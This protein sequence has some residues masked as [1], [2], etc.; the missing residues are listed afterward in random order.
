LWL[1]SRVLEMVMGE[2]PY[3]GVG[4]LATSFI[5]RVNWSTST[6]CACR[7]D[8]RRLASYCKILCT[9]ISPW[10]ITIQK[11]HIQTI[12]IHAHPPSPLNPQAFHDSP[13]HEIN[14]RRA[15]QVSFFTLPKQTVVHAG[16][17]DDPAALEVQDR[18]CSERAKKGEIQGRELPEVG[19]VEIGDC[20]SCKA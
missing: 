4:S 2:R 18:I 15:E 19:E 3:V 13:P 20:L 17:R 6:C 16:Q 1:T 14:N 8:K 10:T 5:L 11:T 9:A 7:R 12:H